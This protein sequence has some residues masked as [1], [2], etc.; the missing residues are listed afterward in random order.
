MIQS[1]NDFTDSSTQKKLKRRLFG[2]PDQKKER[3]QG[4]R[5]K[6]G[7]GPEQ[8]EVVDSALTPFR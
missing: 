4:L 1:Q 8:L 2:R 3:E 6:E 7:D 5:K